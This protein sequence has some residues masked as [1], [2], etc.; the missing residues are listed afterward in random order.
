MAIS[1]VSPATEV[2]TKGPIIDASLAAASV[3]FAQTTI[4]S[5]G[6]AQ[7]AAFNVYYI[8]EVQ[9]YVHMQSCGHETARRRSNTLKVLWGGSSLQFP[10]FQKT[11]SWWF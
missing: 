2:L 9:A 5:T 1:V 3:V 11:L 6:P 7:D 4:T 10:H 8:Q